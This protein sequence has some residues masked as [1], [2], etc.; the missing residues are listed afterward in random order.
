[1]IDFI[2]RNDGRP[3]DLIETR[4][5][6]SLTVSKLVFSGTVRV[7]DLD[8][9]LDGVADTARAV[10]VADKVSLAIRLTR[11]IGDPSRERVAMAM[12]DPTGDGALTQV[13]F[14]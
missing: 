6:P 5:Y 3:D 12:A 2:N 4:E 8:R 13:E 9:V 11:P 7:D 10:A 14:A 1:M